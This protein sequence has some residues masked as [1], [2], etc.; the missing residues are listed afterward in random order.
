MGLVYKGECNILQMRGVWIMIVGNKLIFFRFVWHFKKKAFYNFFFII[1][2]IQFLF[3]LQFLGNK[4]ELISIFMSIFGKLEKRCSFGMCIGC[5]KLWP[6]AGTRQWQCR[7]A[8]INLIMLRLWLA[9]SGARVFFW[10]M[11]CNMFDW[12]C[13]LHKFCSLTNFVFRICL[14]AF[15]QFLKFPAIIVVVSCNLGINHKFIKHPNDNDQ[16]FMSQ[17]LFLYSTFMYLTNFADVSA[18]SFVDFYRFRNFHTI[19][20][21]IRASIILQF[22][23]NLQSRP[24]SW[25]TFQPFIWR[26]QVFPSKDSSIPWCFE[27][28]I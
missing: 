2:K 19:F 11:S 25:L 12:S 9:A 10:C 24:I 20:K 27:T 21:K 1:S 15:Q 28:L 22:Q 8:R 13:S 5:C 3:W 6:A 17:Y 16:L 7:C 26:F 14:V 23:S 18:F 4:L